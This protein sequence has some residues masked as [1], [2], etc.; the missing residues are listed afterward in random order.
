MLFENDVLY[1]YEHDGTVKEVSLRHNRFTPMAVDSC[2]K[3]CAQLDNFNWFLPADGR[4][5]DLPAPGVGDRRI[6]Q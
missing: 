6:G 3:G 2:G 5:G 1:A 4:A